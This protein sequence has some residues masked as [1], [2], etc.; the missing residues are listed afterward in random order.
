MHQSRSEQIFQH[1]VKFATP[2]STSLGHPWPIIPEASGRF[3]GWPIAS[4]RFR[5]WLVDSF[6]HEHSLY[7]GFHAINSALTMFAARARFADFPT[8][9]T[10]TRIGL[11]GHPRRPQAILIHLAHPA[12]ELI[13]IPAAAHRIISA[14]GWHFLAGSSTAALPRPARTLDAP[15]LLL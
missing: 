1:A 15:V 6:Y 8:T 9:D 2:F 7:P 5:Q 3:H 12:N 13:E 14:D 4:A 10:F 11:R